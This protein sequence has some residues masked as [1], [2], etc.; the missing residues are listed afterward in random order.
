MLHL[1]FVYFNVCLWEEKK[2][3][4]RQGFNKSFFISNIEMVS[5]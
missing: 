1:K 2:I 3:V 4:T 5:Y